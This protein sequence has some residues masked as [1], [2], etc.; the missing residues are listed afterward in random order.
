MPLPTPF[1]VW[2]AARERIPK[3]GTSAAEGHSSPYEMAIF[4]LGRATE[5]LATSLA[6]GEDFN[7]MKKLVREY[8]REFAHAEKYIP[9]LGHII[10][11]LYELEDAI[12]HRDI[13][14]ARGIFGE[15]E[16]RLEIIILEV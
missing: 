15:I 14:K 1:E 13:T 2:E 5:E 9:K 4:D 8:R 11:K 7:E 3:G 6:E 16:K 12:L 10:D